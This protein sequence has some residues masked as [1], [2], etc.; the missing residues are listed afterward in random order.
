MKHNYVFRAPTAGVNRTTKELTMRMF[1]LR[2]EDIE[3]EEKDMYFNKA[4]EAIDRKVEECFPKEEY[5]VIYHP[6]V[7]IDGSTM[8]LD[9]VH[10]V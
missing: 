2:L 8:S 3:D 9:K 6:V 10:I 7:S 4:K 5:E 1:G